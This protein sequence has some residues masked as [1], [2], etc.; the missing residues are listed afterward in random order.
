MAWPVGLK[1]C[2]AV[3]N[4]STKPASAGFSLFAQDTHAAIQLSAIV[5]PDGATL[6]SR[7]VQGRNAT[8][9][10]NLLT[11]SFHRVIS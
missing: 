4:P 1:R 3:T 11:L 8:F 6:I 10:P 9:Q 5:L 7:T 2:L